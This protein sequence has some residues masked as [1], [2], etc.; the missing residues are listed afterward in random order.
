MSSTAGFVKGDIENVGGGSGLQM[1][2]QGLNGS[3]RGG[4]LTETDHTRSDSFSSRVNEESTRD[5]LGNSD[6]GGSESRPD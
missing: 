1:T 4:R 5:P 2:N 6:R 3:R